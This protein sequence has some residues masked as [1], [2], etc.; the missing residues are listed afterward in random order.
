MASPVDA[1]SLITVC[2]IEF[3]LISPFSIFTMS[4]RTDAALDSGPDP[5]AGTAPADIDA[6]GNE[7]K[8][9]MA[10]EIIRLHA[11]G[12]GKKKIAKKVKGANAT[13]V[14]AVLAA[15]PA[16]AALAAATLAVAP[17]AV[18]A[19]AAASPESAAAP[20][21]AL[22]PP[23]ADKAEACREQLRIVHRALA[24]LPADAADGERD[25]LARTVAELEQD[26]EHLKRPAPA[27]GYQPLEEYQ[28]TD[29]AANPE[30]P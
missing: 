15:A 16:P 3:I 23:A 7:F 9:A 10:A 27:A 28:A 13:I 29:A 22:S 24:E 1:T 25:T 20:A 17:A 18:A 14:R 21:R 6:R 26:L 2:V 19:G 12:I 5:A 11:L 8:L 4:V 30:T